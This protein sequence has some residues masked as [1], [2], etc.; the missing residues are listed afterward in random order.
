MRILTS[1]VV[2][3]SVARFAHANQGVRQRV[4]SCTF[5]ARLLVFDKTSAQPDF[6]VV[7]FWRSDT[8]E[9]VL[10]LY[11][12]TQPDIFAVMNCYVV[13]LSFFPPIS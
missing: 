3:E 2:N 5:Y 12:N 11:Y 10:L 8:D 6:A 4:P 1:C 9:C 7:L 13:A